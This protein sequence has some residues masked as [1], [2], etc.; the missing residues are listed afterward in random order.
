MKGP[1]DEMWDVQSTTSQETFKTADKE[2]GFS[3]DGATNSA[4]QTPKNESAVAK[5]VHKSLWA[6][7]A[8]IVRLGWIQ[9][10]DA[11]DSSDKSVKKSSSSNSQSTEGWLSSQE[12]D[13]DGTRK[14]YGTTKV[15]DQQLI[16]SNSGEPE[17]ML[18]SLPME[19][20]SHTDTQ[21][22]L[23]PGAG[24]VPQVSRSEGDLLATSSKADQNIS[25]GRLKQSIAGESSK[26]SSIEGSTPSFADVT[27]GHSLDP[28]SAA[29]S[30]RIT[31]KSSGE[32][33][34]KR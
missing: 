9:R 6:Y 19:E 14:K 1:T 17:S 7:V 13:N 27:I 30:S 32:N 21:G 10:G 11:H 18:V 8:D 20:N 2:E 16:K 5:N 22:L 3:I 24:I 26:G 29:T 28:I 12:H 23:I 33:T 31:A 4:S 25:A 15:K 34:G